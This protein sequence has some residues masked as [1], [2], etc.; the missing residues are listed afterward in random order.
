MSTGLTIAVLGLTFKPDTDDM[1]DAPSVPLIETLQRFGA[2]V[3]A[4]DPVG[5]GNASRILTDVALFEDPYECCQDADAVVVVT[6]W[7]SIREMDLARL[8]SVMRSPTSRSSQRLP[9]GRRQE[10]R[11][12]SC[13]RR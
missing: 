7:N 12:L 5:M 2:D 6:E 9:S 1:R 13:E 11:A 10:S 3:R 4:H 8:T